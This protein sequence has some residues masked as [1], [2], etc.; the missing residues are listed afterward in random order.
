MVFKSLF[1]AGKKALNNAIAG[2]EKWNKQELLNCSAWAAACV[3][4]SDGTCSADEQDVAIANMVQ[5]CKNAFS[6]QEATAAFV[7][8]R[9]QF[10]GNKRLALVSMKTD[11]SSINTTEEKEFILAIAEAVAEADGG[12]E[13][14]SQEREA[15]QIIKD[16]L[17]LS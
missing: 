17:G 1:D 13:I 11:F 6:T 7:E 9:N 12:K 16:A 5:I 8:K 14:A 15:I 3:A 2:I 10:K 4:A